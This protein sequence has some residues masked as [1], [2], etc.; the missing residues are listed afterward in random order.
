MIS[1]RTLRTRVRRV[2]SHCATKLQRNCNEIRPQ[3]HDESLPKVAANSA[4]DRGSYP[5]EA[6]SPGDAVPK[7]EVETNGD[8][9]SDPIEVPSPDDAGDA[10]VEE[11]PPPPTVS[12]K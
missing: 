6:P 3:N 2:R 10:N 4:S 8:R 12:E 7:D 9:G 5:P 11:I 1:P